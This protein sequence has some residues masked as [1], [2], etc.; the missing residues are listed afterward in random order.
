MRIGKAF[1][2][3]VEL[4]LALGKRNMGSD[5]GCWEHQVDERW[6]FALNPHDDQTECSQGAKVPP[7][8][9]YVQFNGWPAGIIGVSDGVMAAGELAN[10]ATFIEALRVA[11][12]EKT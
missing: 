9:I 6:W 8:S 4:G 2:A 5:P 1:A 7:F 3:V 12:S 10:E 11:G